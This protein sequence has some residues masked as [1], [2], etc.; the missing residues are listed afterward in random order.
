MEHF[1]DRS[2]VWVYLSNRVFSDVESSDISLAIKHFCKEWSAHGTKLKAAGEVR[3]N[4][5]IILMVDE[6]AAGASGC[7]IDKSIHF[8]QALEKE[9]DVRLFDRLL[10]AWK[11]EADVHVAPM[12]NLQQLFDD[13]TISPGTIVYNNAVTSKKDLEEKWE[14][15][16]SQ[17]WMF[18]RI[19]GSKH[20]AVP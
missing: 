7:S 5:F 10:L 9:Y 3:Y 13:G 20:N 12:Q 15:P 11:D 2:R 17:S 16:F 18:A 19:N 8:I 14:I 1:N 6:T 4:R